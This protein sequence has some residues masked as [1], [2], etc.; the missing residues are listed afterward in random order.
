MPKPM[1]IDT[2]Y[3]RDFPAVGWGRVLTLCRAAPVAG[4]IVQGGALE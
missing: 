1:D 2:T 4:T 3:R